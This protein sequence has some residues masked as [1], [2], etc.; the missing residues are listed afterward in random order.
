MKK[1]FLRG[2]NRERETFETEKERSDNEPNLQNFDDDDDD[3]ME[4]IHEMSKPQNDEIQKKFNKHQLK[5]VLLKIGLRHSHEYKAEL[6]D[7]FFRM[8]FLHCVA[9]LKS[10][11]WFGPPKLHRSQGYTLWLFILSPP[12]LSSPKNIFDLLPFSSLATFTRI[13]IKI[14]TIKMIRE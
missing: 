10:L 1:L 13:Q 5:Y 6:P 3:Q 9:F 7:P 11:S 12:K 8:R 4:W 14:A 2:K